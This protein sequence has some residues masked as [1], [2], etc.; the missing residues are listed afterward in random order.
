MFFSILGKE[1]KMWLK[2]V[3]FYAYFI[4][5]VMFYITQMDSSVL[6]KPAPG[7]DNYGIVYTTDETAIMEH[8]LENL[9]REY[10]QRS[11]TTYPIGFY[12]E[13]IPGEDDMG[14][15]GEIISDI[16]GQEEALWMEAEAPHV[17]EGLRFSEFEEA[18]EEVA[19]LVGP[20]SSYAKESLRQTGIP[21]TYEQALEEYEAICETDRVTGAYARLFCDYV[22]IILGI[23]PAFFGV[24]RVLLDRR[25]QAAQVLYAKSASSAAV[26]AARYLAMV[27]VLFVPV[28]I[29]AHFAALQYIYVAKA[30]GVAPDYLAYA[31]YSVLWLLPTVLFVAAVSYLIAELTESVLS[32]LLCGA[33]WFGSVF[34]GSGMGLRFVGC[35]MIPRFN[36]AGATE[37]FFSMLPELIRNRLA[38]S[39]AAVFLV[40]VTGLI[41]E[42]KRRGG[43]GSGRKIRQNRTGK[44]AA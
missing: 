14:R 8:T 39:A 38:Y 10:G 5:L 27:A 34:M 7:G 28:L 19:G 33:L 35:N 15:I 1:C 23:L 13:V 12:K 6:V 41:Y 2:N 4:V 36:S 29:V 37:Q 25:S 32:V 9:V 31:K 24:A 22:G 44:P 16:T 17:K 21:M 18:M 26:V 3:L 20:G 42:K 40:I 30:L 11:F 43:M